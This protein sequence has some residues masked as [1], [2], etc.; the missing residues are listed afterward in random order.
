MKSD[1]FEWLLPSPVQGES[2][3]WG[4]YAGPLQ[5]EFSPGTITW[6]TESLVN[7]EVGQRVL[8]R[9]Y[10][11]TR[12]TIMGVLGGGQGELDVGGDAY[13]GG[14]TDIAGSLKFDL[15]Y[16]S[17][18]DL[19]DITRGGFYR[20][21]LTAD[22]LASRNY[23]FRAAG[24]LEVFASGN[25]AWQRYT[26]YNNSSSG[27]GVYVRRKYENTWYEWEESQKFDDGNTVWINGKS[28]ARS[29]ITTNIPSYSWAASDPPIYRVSIPVPVP[30]MPPSGYS[31]IWSVMRGTD[32]YI[33]VSTVTPIIASG[34]TQN[35][36]VMQVG[37]SGTDHLTQL[38]WQLVKL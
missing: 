35:V 30:Y 11:G 21:N 34:G 38:A 9:F 2:W 4:R 16:L 15:E 17:T 26:L 1:N 10:S 19:N 5:V 20:Q 7:A 27:S 37:S 25:M 23:P 32:A 28:Y 12:A 24:L 36:R 33:F 29:G 18:R 14:N 3:R 8:V 22:A 13:I 6:V 31:F